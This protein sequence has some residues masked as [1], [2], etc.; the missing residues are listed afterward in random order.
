MTLFAQSPDGLR[1]AYE[2]VG[3]GPAVLLVHG[4]ASSRAQNWGATGWYKVLADAGVRVI[5]LDCRGH[6]DSDKPH[7]P[8]HYSSALM[9][10]DILAVAA[11]TGARP[12]DLVGYSMGGQLALH[13]LLNSPQAIRKVAIAGVGESYL[14]GDPPDRFAIADALLAPDPERLVDPVQ[15]LF[16]AFAG[17]PG[18]DRVA[19][20]AC[21]R[22]ERRFFTAAELARSTRP[23]LVVCGGNDTVS[24]RARPLAEALHDGRGVTIPGRD[25]M[26]AVGDKATKAAV[27]EFLT[28]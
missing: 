10:A 12:A 4:F 20:A 3:E 2:V 25:H 7:D 5:A 21:M 17:Q 22:G 23:A 16:R 15:K 19:L 9:S 27:V 13:L 18:K 24:G 8:A 26:S 6:G 28:K 11:A 1:I 14:C